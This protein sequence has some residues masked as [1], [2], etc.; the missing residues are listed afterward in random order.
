MGSNP[1]ICLDK[2]PFRREGSF[3]LLPPHRREHRAGDCQLP[4]FSTRSWTL[5]PLGQHLRN[6]GVSRVHATLRG[7]CCRVSASDAVGC[8]PEGHV[9]EWAAGAAGGAGMLGTMR[10][11]R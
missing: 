5:L 4:D 9:P 10:K 7:G 6:N 3:V 11:S 8:F 1:T 2:G